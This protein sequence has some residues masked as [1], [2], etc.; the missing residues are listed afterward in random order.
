MLSHFNPHHC[1]SGDLRRRPLTRFWMNFN[2]H[3]CISGD[4]QLKMHHLV[5]YYFNPHHCISGDVVLLQAQLPAGISIHTTVSVVTLSTTFWTGPP[6]YFN[7][8]HCISGDWRIIRR[9]SSRLNFNP[10]HCISGDLPVYDIDHDF[11][12][13]IHTNVSVVTIFLFRLL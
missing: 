6:G 12:I 7:P 5:Y 9:R 4:Y 8:H 11:D 10:H 13:S 2:P 1:I 3:H